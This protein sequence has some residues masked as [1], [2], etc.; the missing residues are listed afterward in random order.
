MDTSFGS[1]GK[2]ISY[3]D[4]DKTVVAGLVVQKTDG[5]IVIAAESIPINEGASNFAVFRYTRDGV[6]DFDFGNG[7]G[8]AFVDLGLSLPDST[9]DVGIQQD[10]KIVVVG[11]SKGYDNKGDFGMVR[12]WP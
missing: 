10:G 4:G 8:M 9:K 7:N 5:K 1:N 6:L 2:V 12:F 11:S 3:I